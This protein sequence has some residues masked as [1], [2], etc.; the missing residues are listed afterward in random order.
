[1]H[2]LDYCHKPERPRHR[3]KH[4]H[5]VLSG[6]GT[7]LCSL[8]CSAS[9]IG[10]NEIPTKPYTHTHT[11]SYQ[12]KLSRTKAKVAQNAQY[13]SKFTLQTQTNKHKELAENVRTNKKLR[14]PKYP[15][16]PLWVSNL[17]GLVAGFIPHRLCHGTIS[18]LIFACQKFPWRNLCLSFSSFRLDWP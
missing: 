13:T 5:T 1:M 15:I 11:H 10:W 4:T 18:T 3:D 16:Y 2:H 7:F 14:L 12:L 17:T 9:V 6:P 8:T